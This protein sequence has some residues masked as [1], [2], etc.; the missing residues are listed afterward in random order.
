MQDF[1][2][3]LQNCSIA[4]LHCMS[5]KKKLKVKAQCTGE[6]IFLNHTVLSS[7]WKILQVLHAVLMHLLSVFCDGTA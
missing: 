1:K 3:Y 7:E 5:K 4:E 6:R 2:V